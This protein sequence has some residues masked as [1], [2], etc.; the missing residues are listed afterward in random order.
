[1][2]TVYTATIT[3][4]PKTGYTLTGVSE[5]F[6][7]VAGTSAHATNDANSGVV[8]AVFPQT[9]AAP[10]TGTCPLSVTDNENNEYPVVR[11]AGICWTAANLKNSKYNDD[12]ATPILFAK[13][14]YSTLYPN[15][16][17][18]KNNYGLLYDYASASA[19]SRSSQAPHLI[20]P[21]G[22]RIPT[23]AEWVSLNMY[24]SDD[25]KNA[26]F[27]A[28]PNSNT[29]NTGLDIRGSGYYNSTLQTFERLTSYTAFW[30][31]DVPYST[32]CN[33]ACLRYNCNEIEIVEIKLTDAVSVRCVLDE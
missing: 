4:T 3:I 31:S 26:G 25:L 29:N 15:L 11:L 16:T 8:T 24:F 5:D 14:Y 21:D 13:P 22:W 10:P 2:S 33:A 18:N 19:V 20:C 12:A 30:S 1:Y 9:E 28:Q 17:Q 6:F 7:T 32:T 27:W 23:S